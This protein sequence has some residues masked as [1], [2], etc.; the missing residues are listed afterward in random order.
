MGVTATVVAAGGAAYTANESQ[1]AAKKAEKDR[2]KAEQ[3]MKDAE[4]AASLKEAASTPGPS[5]DAT[6]RIALERRYVKKQQGKGRSGTVMG[7][8]GTLG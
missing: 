6:K 5:M 2:K 3:E 7:Q 4:T 1:K 8:T